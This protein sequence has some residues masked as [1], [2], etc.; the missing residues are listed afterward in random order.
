MGS[1]SWQ[2]E[3]LGGAGIGVGMSAGTESSKEK[4]GKRGDRMFAVWLC[5]VGCGSAACYHQPP[6][7]QFNALMAAACQC[8]DDPGSTQVYPVS[9]DAADG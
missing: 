1:Y 3:A 8:L 6:R 2:F 9:T 7:T 5:G 4:Q